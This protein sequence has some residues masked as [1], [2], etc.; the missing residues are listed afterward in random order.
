MTMLAWL[1]GAFTM[2]RRLQALGGLAAEVKA[3][4]SV[5]PG[6]SFAD[7]LMRLAVVDVVAETR[8]RWPLVSIAVVVDDL[9]STVY[10]EP[11]YVEKVATD[12]CKFM[13]RRLADKGLPVS[14]PKVQMVGTN[15]KMLR[16]IARR[17]LPLRKAAARSIRNLGRISP[18]AAG[19]STRCGG[20]ASRR[21]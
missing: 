13:V 6:S 17:C 9:Q 10:G 21:S 2:A 5:V 3:S 20:N 1:L 19:C 18:A 8:I 12:S 11:G 16:R 4:R 14:E 7:I 15:G